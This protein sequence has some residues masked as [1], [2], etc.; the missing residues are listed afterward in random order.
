MWPM[1][2]LTIIMFWYSWNYILNCCISH[3]NFPLLIICCI[4]VRGENVRKFRWLFNWNDYTQLSEISE[5]FADEMNIRHF[6]TPIYSQ[7]SKNMN[8]IINRKQTCLKRKTQQTKNE[9][10]A[11]DAWNDVNNQLLWF[12]HSSISIWVMCLY[13]MSVWRWRWLSNWIAK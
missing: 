2:F 11:K 9:M 5:F 7:T 8:F 4:F 3:R 12:L 10:H 1:D 6:F 13:A